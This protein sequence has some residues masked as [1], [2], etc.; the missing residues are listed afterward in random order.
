[1]IVATFF[2]AV[3]QIILKKSAVKTKE[4]KFLEKFLNNSVLLAY[5]IFGLVCLVNIYA[6]RG[7]DFKY[8]GSI[9]AI[10]QIFVLVLS[11]IFCN[12]RLSKN[13]IVGS[14]LITLGIL[15]YSLR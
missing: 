7:V 13:R 4:M 9:N 6:Y 3:S 15:I 12:E 5:I 2:N 1:M 14:V 10:G 11:V 8:G